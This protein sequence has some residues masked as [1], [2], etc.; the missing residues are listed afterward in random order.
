MAISSGKIVANIFDPSRGGIGSKLNIPRS[1]FNCT[2][3]NKISRRIVGTR[4]PSNLISKAKTTA[5][6]KFIKGPASETRAMSFLPSRRLNGSTGT[7]L[8]APKIIG[9]PER[10]RRSGSKM[11]IQ[12]SM[13]GRGSR[14]SLPSSLAVG[15][16]SL[17]ATKPCETS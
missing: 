12:G 7:G 6:R 11:L 8:A 14:V 10:I 17:S 4:G 5:I 15:S 16:P 9:E 3:L 2:I 13:C 1:K